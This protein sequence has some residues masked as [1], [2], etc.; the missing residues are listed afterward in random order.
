[1]IPP[2]VKIILITLVLLV[3][4]G[5]VFADAIETL[6][7]PGEVINGHKKFEKECNRCHEK[8]SGTSQRG[9]CLDCHDK[10]E[11]DIKGKKGFH[12]LS[13]AA[14]VNDCK[15]CHIEHKGRLAD[16]VKLDTHLFPH[17]HTD[18]PLKGAHISLPCQDCHKPGKKYRE[19]QNQCYQCHEK[20]PH[21]GR[22]GKR[23]TK[24]HTQVLWTEIDFDHNRTDFKLNGKHKELE[25]NVCHFNSKYKDTPKTCIA[26]H[27]VD[28]VHKGKNGNKCQKCHSTRSWGDLK[29]D[30]DRQTK[31]KLRGRHKTL[32][33]AACHIK[34]PW[35]VKI[36][37]DCLSCHKK[38]DR[39]SAQ[40]G[41]KCETCHGVDSWSKIRFDHN[42]DTEYRLVGQH[43]QAACVACHK[44]HL[45]RTK[46]S[47]QCV[48][49]HRPDDVHKG[50]EGDKCEQCH[51]P[52]G[53][54]SVYGF[55]HDMSYFPLTGLHALVAC[56]SCHI[57]N[58]FSN[59]PTQC[60][61]CHQDDEHH[62]R[63][64]SRC[65]QCHNTNGWNIWRFDHNKDTDFRLD[66]AHEKIHCY[67]CHNT[68]VEGG[69][70]LNQSCGYCHAADD[71]HNNQFGNQCEQCHNTTSFT[72]VRIL[73]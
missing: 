65:E 7:M 61:K 1:M 38:D 56:E 22:L 16:I 59:T 71:V 63:L 10:V 58:A 66:G 52:S 41:G 15:T 5:Q 46:T 44:G 55:D 53:W 48:S 2:Q 34:N 12:G 67:E 64:G 51:L 50:K 4:T 18:F 29:F 6:I 25:C 20:N 8:L 73:R 68:P 13:P 60:N 11:A 42:R 39:H 37:S 30:H 23:C 27:G 32:E 35:K 62:G 31:F 36:K 14:S 9:L 47:T 24:C 3:T 40:Y 28:D 33:C 57:N 21:E 19:A 69:V 45:Y 49:C 17:E 43:K 54:K 26:C 72:N 70:A